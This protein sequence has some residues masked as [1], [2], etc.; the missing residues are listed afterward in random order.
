MIVMIKA[1]LDAL[2]EYIS[3]ACRQAIRD[4]PPDWDVNSLDMADLRS[5]IR[6][7]LLK[8]GILPKER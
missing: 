2:V 3:I 6:T 1:E 7:A 4:L 5:T 8:Y